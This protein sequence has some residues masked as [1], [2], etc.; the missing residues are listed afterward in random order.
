MGE[1]EIAVMETLADCADMVMVASVTGLAVVM[2]HLWVAAT[3]LVILNETLEAPAA[4]EELHDHL[5]DMP[6]VSAVGRMMPGAG[7]APV[8]H[9]EVG[10]EVDLEVVEDGNIAEVAVGSMTGRAGAVGTARCLVVVA[11]EFLGE[12]DMG[13]P[14]SESLVWKFEDFAISGTVYQVVTDHHRAQAARKTVDQAGPR[15]RGL[16][17]GAQS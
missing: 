4:E 11:V 7:R 2:V 14:I 5:V 10:L 8:A 3:E 17:V 9:L 1:R 13:V 6:L 15:S 16:L 12:V